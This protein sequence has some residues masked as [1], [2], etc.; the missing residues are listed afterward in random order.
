M[1]REKSSAGKQAPR[2]QRPR[3]HF[4]IS[5][6]R[7]G[8][9]T[10]D[11]AHNRDSYAA[12]RELVQN[13]LDAAPEA[14]K[15]RFIAES[16][17]KTDIP[18]IAEYEQAF[19][20]AC[21]WMEEAGHLHGQ[22]H[23]IANL[24]RK[25]L[26]RKEIPML[27]VIDNGA[28]LNDKRM[29][30]L[31]SDGAG[32][33]RK[34]DAGSYGVGHLAAFSLSR[35]NYMLYG[36]F[37]EGRKICS[38]HAQLASHP[39]EDNSA[40]GKDGRL[41]MDARANLFKPYTFAAGGQVP[42]LL[43]EKLDAIRDESDFGSGSVVA[44]VAFNFF[45]NPRRE[46]RQFIQSIV[47]EN[48]Y[49]AIDGGKLAVEIIDGESKSKLDGKNLAEV[50]GRGQ[51]KRRATARNFP[52]GQRVAESYDTLKNG[53][54]LEMPFNGEKIPVRVRE[55]ARHRTNI[56]ICRKGMWIT[57]SY[58][59]ICHSGHYGERVQFDALLLIEPSASVVHEVVRDAEGPYHN[60]LDPKKH[61]GGEWESSPP[62]RGFDLA[63]VEKNLTD[64][65]KIGI[66]AE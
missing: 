51:D 25:E 57:D 66:M 45:G 20:S 44:V 5:G 14:A 4:P 38:G 39:G 64:S 52:S 19:Q 63:D 26:Q 58:S 22:N 36:G 50:I 41:V 11:V 18:A 33:K 9:S 7:K 65:G 31:L 49:P 32:T 27:Y 21:K 60:E 10:A 13:S 42:D 40:R 37:S 6:E 8:F 56:V 15:I 59:P 62:A 46:M 61:M 53:R 1:S 47:A 28:G 43:S 17:K 12:V 34:G 23:N 3:L 55:N 24:I 30:S 29:T 48:F 35:M 16:V 54:T 2:D